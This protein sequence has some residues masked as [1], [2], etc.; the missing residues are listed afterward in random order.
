MKTLFL[1]LLTGFITLTCGAKNLHF[2]IRWK[3][4]NIVE[5]YDHG[6]KIQVY[7]D[8]NLTGESQEVKESEFGEFSCSVSKGN[9]QIRIVNWTHYGEQWEEHTLANEYSI[10][11]M[12]EDEH[13]FSR[14][15]TLQIVWDLD[16][17]N[18]SAEWS[19][20]KKL[21]TTSSR[22]ENTEITW[23]FDGI[24]E[25]YDHIC[26]TKVYVDN[27]LVAT[28][29]EAL[30][31]AGGKIV[32]KIK[33]GTHA[34]RIVSECNYEGK[35]EEHTL[36]NGYSIDAQIIERRTFS[37][38]NEAFIHFDINAETTSIEWK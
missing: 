27:K 14:S 32:L 26:R 36:E 6:N 2:T 28:S 31:S 24:Q 9:H 19:D 13:A 11:A 17:V 5:G 33:P 22:K 12:L 21:K 8:D 35:W 37:S 10:D 18:S 34:I 30:E 29:S 15:V 4:S 38:K 23:K 1:V 25:G 7:I 16:G 3:F 20:V